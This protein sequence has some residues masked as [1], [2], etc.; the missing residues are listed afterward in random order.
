VYSSGLGSVEITLLTFGAVVLVISHIIPLALLNVRSIIPSGTAC[1]LCLLAA[2][3]KQDVPVG[4][5]LTW[6]ANV[7]SDCLC[8]EVPSWVMKSVFADK[9]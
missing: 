1:L 9:M 7:I 8:D 3:A 4:I 2:T 5:F 6:F